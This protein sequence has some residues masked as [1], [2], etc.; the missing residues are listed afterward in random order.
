MLASLGNISENPRIGAL[1]VDFVSDLIG[2]HVNGAASI[3]ADAVLRGER[4]DLPVDTERG[5]MPAPA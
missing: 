2:L 3:V 1:M 5:R 4:P